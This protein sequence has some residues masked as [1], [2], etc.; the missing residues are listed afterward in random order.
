M[1]SSVIHHL[2]KGSFSVRLSPTEWHGVALDECH[3]M[4]VNKDAKLAV[5]HPSK[6]KMEFLSNYLSFRAACVG[7]LKKQIFP[8]REQHAVTFS[9]SAT[10]KDRKRDANVRHMLDA[11]QSKGML[12]Y[13]GLW[14][15]FECKQA[16][17]EQAHD[18]LNFRRIGMEAFEGLVSEKL[19]GLPSTAA[20]TRRKRL[21]TFSVSK[22]QKQRVK[23]VEQERKISQRYL[24]RQLAWI[25][26]QGAENLDLD[27][28]L[29][30]ISSLPRALMDKDGLPYKSTKSSTTEY[31]HK[32]YSSLQILTP[33]LPPQWVPHAAILEGMF[34]IQTSPLPTMSSMNE[35]AHFLLNQYV[36]PHLRVGVQEVHVVFD[37][38]GSMRESPKEL[39][40]RRRDGSVKEHH[41][42]AEIGH[43][44]PLP[45][46]G[47]LCLDA[48][49]VN[50]T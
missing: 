4:K 14:N 3:E 30:P 27:S 1:P 6:H 32:R 37:S 35:Y 39:E 46:I 19:L 25:S 33:S 9:H 42:C 47:E 10:S 23:L 34:M 41:D 29:G 2:Q 8:E 43:T 11:I 24:K 50:R 20:P 7:N 12:T 48:E 22:A 38:P 17:P 31:L 13:T 49:S 40:Q 28:L 45:S 26:E 36:R 15:V 18:L 5:I 16:T 21:C 44:S